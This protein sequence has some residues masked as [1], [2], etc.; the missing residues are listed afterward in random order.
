MGVLLDVIELILGRIKTTGAPKTNMLV[1]FPGL[2]WNNRWN[3]NLNLKLDNTHNST[4]YHMYICKLDTI[5]KLLK[6][7]NMEFEFIEGSMVMM[8]LDVALG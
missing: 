8:T 1:S 5:P 2:P 7:M 3:G 6:V 4:Y